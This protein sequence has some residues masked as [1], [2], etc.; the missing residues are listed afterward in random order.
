[1]CVV[2]GMMMN[3][4]FW[5]ED[6]KQ[7]VSPTITQKIHYGTFIIL[8]IFFFRLPKQDAPFF[9][10]CVWLWE[11][12]FED[13]LKVKQD[14]FLRLKLQQQTKNTIEIKHLHD[15]VSWCFFGARNR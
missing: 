13:I 15:H 10:S 5:K 2:G 11:Q 1:M 9:L 12:S 4:K 6:K 8:N 3:L 7:E 14:R